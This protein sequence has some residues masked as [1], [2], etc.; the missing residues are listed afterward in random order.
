[1]EAS[2]RIPPLRLALL[3][4]AV[5]SC[6][7]FYPRVM[8]NTRLLISFCAAIAGLLFF[9]FVLSRQVARA[10]RKLFYKVVA[11]PVH[12]VQ[13]VMHCSIY[14]YW[15]WYWREVYHFAPLIIAQLVFAY[16]LDMM[17]C[18][19]QRDE[20]ILGFGPFPIILSTNLFLWFRDDWFYFQFLM[21]AVGV[22]GK[23]FLK[24][25]REGKLTHI[26]N[27]SALALFVA[28]VILIATKL[29]DVTWGIQI[30][31]SLHR[32]PYIYFEIFILGLIVQAL[33]G[34]TLVTL[35]AAVVLCGLNLAYTHWTGVYHFI[36]S[37]I[38]VSV[39]IG[40]HLLVTDPATSP[41]TRLG[42]IMFGGLYGAGVFVMYGFLSWIAA[43]EFYDKLLCV[44]ALNL[45]VR[46]FDQMGEVIA[47]KFRWL[48]SLRWS[49]QKVNYVFMAIWIA[50]FSTM[51]GTGFLAKGTAFPG[52][53]IAFWQQAC[54]EGR[55]NACKTWVRILKV[56]CDDGS[57]GACVQAGDLMDQG[58]VVPRN[59]TAAGDSYGHGCDLG[60]SQGCQRLVNFV[61]DGGKDVF[62][63]SCYDGDGASCFILGSLYSAGYGVPK[64]PAHAFN[65]FQQS[66]LDGWWR[67]CGR[68][69][70]SYLA[71]QGTPVNPALAVENLEKA[72]KG[73]N[74]ASCYEVGSLYARG[75]G[76]LKDEKL[77]RQRFRQ[78]CDLGLESACAAESDPAFRNVGIP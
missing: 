7:C 12:Y 49:P 25:R 29:T 69:G 63:Q 68:L 34:V 52:G 66:C 2:N 21:I 10:R 22:L 45:G 46:G 50:L 19:S 6:F 48:G 56:T 60:S 62:Y 4:I 13:L 30:S 18:W 51:V 33:F 58:R 37:A 28:S 24:W 76:A 55:W 16:A 67:G 74:A 41:R 53:N 57:A 61:T 38:P 39:F 77:A 44:P 59:A 75:L 26:F 72:C 78:A 9:V 65:L 73:M 42:K 71:G 64:D 1:M 36:D 35:S 17:V 31:A 14:A 11:R 8:A 27:P 15:G 70:Q 23:E 3:F 5:L 54:G 47:S 43:P 20:W 40:L 32:P